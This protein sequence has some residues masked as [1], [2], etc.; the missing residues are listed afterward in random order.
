MDGGGR[1]SEEQLAK[2][3]V[4]GLY[5]ALSSGDARRAQELLAPD[6]GWWFH[7]PPAHQHM[8]RLLTGAD[9]QGE[10]GFAFSPRSVDAFGD[11]VI[12]EGTDGS[13]QLY[14]VHAWTV[15]PDGVI[16]QLREYFNTDLTVT[17]LATSAAAMDTAAISSNLAAAASS[18]A[19]PARAPAKLKCLWKSRR[20]DREHK[21]LPG[22]VLAI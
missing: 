21:S 9:Q 1:E 15:G 18:S 8:M 11:T 6:L 13:R 19:F 16:T 14:W 12:A 3:L 10:A 7:G 22:L 20:A 5:E 17:R 2:F 4:L